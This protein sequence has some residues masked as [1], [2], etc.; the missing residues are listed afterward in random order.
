[1][2]IVR[3]LTIIFFV[4]LICTAP[5]L[6]ALAATVP[7]LDLTDVMDDLDELKIDGKAFDP[8]DYLS[9]SQGYPEFLGM[10]EH[11]F[12]TDQY[13]LYFFFYVPEILLTFEDGYVFNIKPKV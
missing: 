5:I 13:S 7:K 9:R 10:Y 4:F 6:S 8:E 12:G 3:N 11:G 2:K 1:M